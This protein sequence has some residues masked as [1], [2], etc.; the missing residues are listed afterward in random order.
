VLVGTETGDDAA[1]LKIN[2]DLALVQTVDFFTPIVDDPLPV[3]RDLGGQ[4]FERR[5]LP[6]AAP[7]CSP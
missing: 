5:L 1:V 2:S 7:P 3:R 6:W 4:L